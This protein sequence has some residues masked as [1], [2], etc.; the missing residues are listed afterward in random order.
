M[1]TSLPRCTKFPLI[2][3]NHKGLPYVMALDQHYVF[4]TLLASCLHSQCNLVIPSRGNP[5]ECL[6]SQGH[7]F[8]LYCHNVKLV[9]VTLTFCSFV[10]L[11]FAVTFFPPCHSFLITLTF[12]SSFMLCFLIGCKVHAYCLMTRGLRRFLL[13]CSCFCWCVGKISH[14]PVDTF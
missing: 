10:S 6:F 5:I 8:F 11:V 1:F 14:K 13:V 9:R 3:T 2:Y 4:S 7:F 12:A